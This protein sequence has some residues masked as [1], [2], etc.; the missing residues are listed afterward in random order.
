MVIDDAL[1]HFTLCATDDDDLCYESTNKTSAFNTVSPSRRPIDSM[2]A[3]V[4]YRFTCGVTSDDD[5]AC[6]DG[7]QVTPWVRFSCAASY[8]FCMG[9]Q[10][11]L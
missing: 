11:D 6:V 5:S 3:H 7:V 9:K 2:R 8:M 10:Y 4:Y 1:L